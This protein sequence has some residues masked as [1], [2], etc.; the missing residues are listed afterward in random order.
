[1]VNIHKL[2]G[3]MVEKG[4]TQG[5][6][7]SSIGMSQNTMSSRMNLRTPFNTDE[8]EL[9]CDRLGITSAKDKIDIFL[10]TPSQNRDERTDA[11]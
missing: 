4:Y 6:L 7:A 1:M 8:I 2:K 10:S 9:I 3:Q 5:S 11:A